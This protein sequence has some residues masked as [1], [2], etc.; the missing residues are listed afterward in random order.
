[1][2]A[3]SSSRSG[4]PCFFNSAEYFFFSSADLAAASALPFSILALSSGFTPSSEKASAMPSAIAPPM[5]APMSM[6]ASIIVAPI[7]SAVVPSRRD[8]GSMQAKISATFLVSPALTSRA[9]R[10]W[11]EAAPSGVRAAGAASSG[12]AASRTVRASEQRRFH[13][14]GSAPFGFGASTAGRRAR[15][16][17]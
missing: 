16:K 1:M 3:L 9:T 7:S 5:P 11:G 17:V 12:C 13:M 6:K 15:P 2:P 8:C 14:S 10:A 4:R